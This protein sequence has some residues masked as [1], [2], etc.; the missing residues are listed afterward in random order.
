MLEGKPPG[1]F[2]GHPHRTAATGW[3]SRSWQACRRRPGLHR[4]KPNCSFP[5]TEEVAEPRRSQCLP[6]A[7]GNA[8]PNSVM[9]DLFRHPPGGCGQASEWIPEQVQGDEEELSGIPAFAGMTEFNSVGATDYGRAYAWLGG[10]LCD[11][12]GSAHLVGCGDVAVLT[13]GGEARDACLQPS[14]AQ[15]SSQGWPRNLGRVMSCTPGGFPPASPGAT[16]RDADRKRR[17]LPGVTPKGL[18]PTSSA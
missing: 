1:A 11:R 15:A 3:T 9:P 16:P 6:Q 12:R 8:R 17:D 14:Y 7:R 4:P 5:A 10:K 13:L 18:S 2:T